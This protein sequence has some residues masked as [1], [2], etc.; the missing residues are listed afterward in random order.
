MR[1]QQEVEIKLQRVRDFLQEHGLAAAVLTTTAN[2]AWL[3]GGGDSHVVIASEGGVGNIVVT[4]TGQHIITNNIEAGRLEDEEVGELPFEIHHMNWHDEN[5]DAML[6]QI[7]SGV[8]ATDGNWPPDATNMASEIARLRWQLLEPEIERYKEVGRLTQQALTET[9]HEVTPGMNEHQIGAA[10]A[11]KV[12]AEGL[13]PAVVLIAADE[14]IYKYRHPI[15]TDK[16][17]ERQA[18]L[19]I[20]A[21]KWGLGISATRLVHFGELPAELADKHSAVCQVDAAFILETR[22]GAAVSDIFKKALAVYEETGYGDEWQ[23]HHQGGATGYAPR[24]YKGGLES[25][26][27]VQQDQAFAWNPSIIGTK[28]EDTIIAR[29]NQTEIISQAED[30]PMVEVEYQ[31]QKITR[32]DILIR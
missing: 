21:V 29:A 27:V 25:P 14:R 24:D 16:H 1:R 17:L 10:L 5:P 11:G 12:L 31:G 15:P 18:M 22:P 13:T 8:M 30:W 9:G 32:P 20:G 3:T 6:S 19:V 7:V 23:L 28:S 4:A 2:F 26:E